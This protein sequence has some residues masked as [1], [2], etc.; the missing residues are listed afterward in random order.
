[1]LFS[2]GDALR[3]EVA[4]WFVAYVCEPMC[5]RFFVEGILNRYREECDHVLVHVPDVRELAASGWN[6]YCVHMSLHRSVL[7]LM[8]ETNFRHLMQWCAED[9]FRAL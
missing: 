2:P 5:L 9:A 1:M 7:C 3:I 6:T 8:F 4:T